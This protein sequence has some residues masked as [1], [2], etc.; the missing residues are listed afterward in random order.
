M[1]QI[2]VSKL[3]KVLPPGT[4]HTR[5]PGYSLELDAGELDLHRFERLV[6]EARASGRRPSGRGVRR[7]RRALGLWSGPALAEFVSEP[8]AASEAG[9]STSFGVPR[10]RV[11][12]KPTSGSA[13]TATSWASSRRL[14][15]RFPLR[16]GLRRQH[17][18]ALYR[19]GRQAEALAAYQD[20]RRALADDLGIEPSPALRELERQILQ[21]DASLDAPPAPSCSRRRPGRR[22][23]HDAPPPCDDASR[24][25]APAEERKRATVLFADLVDATALASGQDPERTRAVA[26]P[27]LRRDGGGDRG[28]GRHGR[29]VRG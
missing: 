15:A 27:L 14:I 9:G 5:P 3:R 11:G 7:L 8:F 22:P 18:L 20:A 25:A 23:R 29:E 19:S 6:A 26:R 4:L 16:E 24:A 1:V 10:S 12:S 28:S 21:Q 13:A 2:H 17:M